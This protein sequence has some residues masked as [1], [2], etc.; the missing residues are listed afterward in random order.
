[1]KRTSTISRYEIV[2]CMAL[3]A[4]AM[5]TTGAMPHAVFNVQAMA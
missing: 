3:A 4:L 2:L 5:S 1:M